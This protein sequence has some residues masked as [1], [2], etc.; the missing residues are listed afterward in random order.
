MV[1][2]FHLV[3][4]LFF[5]AVWSTCLVKVRDLLNLRKSKGMQLSKYYKFIFIGIFA[6]SYL[7]LHCYCPRNYMREFLFHCRGT[8]VA[9]LLLMF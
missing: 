7:S 5:V 9:L 1:S 6:V 2:E 3:P 4:L 8:A